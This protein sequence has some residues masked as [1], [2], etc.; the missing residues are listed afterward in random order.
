[1]GEIRKEVNEAKNNR[2]GAD[3]G[4][5]PKGEGGVFR[6]K[7]FKDYYP[8]TY[9]LRLFLYCE[10]HDEFNDIFLISTF[11]AFIS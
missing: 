6:K 7:T 5:R 8:V 11:Y 9:F 2:S 1:M 4:I 3:S 10:H